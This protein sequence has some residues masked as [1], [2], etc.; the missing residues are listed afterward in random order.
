VLA[1][2]GLLRTGN[3]EEFPESRWTAA[4]LAAEWLLIFRSDHC[5]PPEFREPVLAAL[6]AG[7]ELIHSAVEE[8]VM[9]CSTSFWS[10]GVKIW[11]IVHDAQKGTFHL[12]SSGDVPQNFENIR[13]RYFSEQEREGGE[14]ADVDLIFEIPLEVGLAFTSFR[15]DQE[16]ATEEKKPFEVLVREKHKSLVSYVR[17]PWWRWW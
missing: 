17:K 3:C 10:E 4:N 9:F 8:H 7:C 2:L 14:E 13:E 5:A 1:D 12:Q 6:S 11:E 15:H 16:F